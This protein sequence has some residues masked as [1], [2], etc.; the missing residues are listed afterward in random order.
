MVLKNQKGEEMY[1]VI[2]TS[3][4]EFDSPK[5]RTNTWEKCV[6]DFEELI[7]EVENDNW[8]VRQVKVNRLPDYHRMEATLICNHKGWGGD[9]FK[10]IY[11]D[12][13]WEF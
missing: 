12:S 7:Q 3:S 6:K 9:F 5:I 4:K 2:I 8:S 10:H 13:V 11:I 1:Q